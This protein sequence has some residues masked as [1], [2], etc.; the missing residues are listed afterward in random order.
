MLGDVGRQLSEK[1]GPVVGR[2]IVQQCR[3]VLL[4]HRLDEHS[5]GRGIE[6]AKTSAAN[7]LG[8]T[9]NAST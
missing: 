7:A 4:A 9:L 3:D 1:Q 8:S 2:H 6:Y 5:L